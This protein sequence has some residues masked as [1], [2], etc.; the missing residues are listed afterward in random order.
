M[1]VEQFLVANKV[2]A[3]VITETHV[4]EGNSDDTE[5]TGYI[6]V[7]TCR[8]TGRTN[9]MATG[10]TEGLGGH[11]RPHIRPQRKWL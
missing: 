9:A 8:R 4:H 11:I 10:R 2:H 3:A 6:K 5:L 1:A 7:S